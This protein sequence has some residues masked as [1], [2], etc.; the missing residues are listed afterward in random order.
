MGAR[1]RLTQ[2]NFGVMFATIIEKRDRLV[3]LL[4]SVAGHAVHGRV[5]S[6]DV[7]HVDVVETG[8]CRA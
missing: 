2:F 6:P 7:P 4:D 1:D 3:R 5:P 8:A